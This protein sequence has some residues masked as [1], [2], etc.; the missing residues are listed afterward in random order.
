MTRTSHRAPEPPISKYRWFL[1]LIKRYKAV[2]AGIIA[3]GIVLFGGGAWAVAANTGGS[4]ILCQPGQNAIIYPGGT[5]ACDPAFVP[6]SP[7]DSPSPSTSPSSS[8]SP[9]V[10]PSP[11]AS[12]SSSPS[13][14]TT[15]PSPSPSPTT[16]T[17]APGA[18]PVAG[19]NIAGAA[20]PWGG[21]WPGPG[22]TG[23]PAGTVLTPYAGPCK[24]IKAG[25]TLD[26]VLFDDSKM[27]SCGGVLLIAATGVQITRSSFVGVMID[28]S[29][30]PKAP[31]NSS[32]TISDS[33]MVNPAR[34]WCDC[35]GDRNFTATRIDVSGGQRGFGCDHNCTI[36]DSWVHGQ[37]PVAGQHI[38]GIRQGSYTTVTHSSV[39]CDYD[40]TPFADDRG[41]SAAIVGYGDLAPV[42]HNTF[43]RNL[44]AAPFA[45][46]CI[47][48]GTVAGTKYANYPGEGSY[49]VYTNNVFTLAAP[50]S[51]G[52]PGGGGSTDYK[53]SLP[54]NVW[55]GNVWTDGKVVTGDM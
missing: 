51:C 45:Y 50:G 46:F 16:T 18:C 39:A 14:T 30:N 25:T 12:P 11:S 4:Q 52:L 2:S 40:N 26:A 55:T 33:T 36:I 20:D 34:D 13:P 47:Y 9:S 48:G 54:G 31:F 27:S 17:T 8:P 35:I 6:P 19:K 15:S 21:C 29:D 7:S 22:N 10:S 3:A 44:F 43:D 37:A 24:I 5:W 41:C 23:V 49:I 42:H 28:N 38:S 1:N 32:F 53:A